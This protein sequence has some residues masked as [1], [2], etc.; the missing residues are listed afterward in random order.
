MD[1]TSL[2]SAYAS[3]ALTPGSVIDTL[4]D[5]IA[6]EGLHPVW[7][8]VAPREHALQRA[9]ALA[10]LTAEER[11]K[12]PLFAVPF[13]VKDN[14]D[15][16]GIPTTAGCAEFAYTPTESATVVT[17]L[18]AAGAILIGKTN[19]DQFATGLVGTRSP[20]GAPSSVFNK[21]YIS[22]GSSAG[23]AVA[24]ASGL[25]SFALGTDTAGSGR[26]PAMFNN[27]VGLK[28]TRGVLSNHG[29]VP[30]CRTLDCVSI[31]AETAF[32]ASLVLA[33]TRGFDDKDSLSRT[34]PVGGGAAPW[35]AAETFRFGVPSAGQL[36]FFGD[37]HNLALFQAAVQKLT[38]LGG[39][40]VEFDL[41]PFLAAAQL[42]Y[43]GPW[44]AERYAAI[45][46]FIESHAA[47]MDPS[48]REIILGARDYSAVDTFEAIYQL[49]DLRAKTKTAWSAFDLIVLPTAP[50]TYTHAEI[51][52]SPIE[53]NSHLGYYTNFVNLLD[54]SAIAVPAGFRPD[55]LA[56]GV[57]LIAQAFQEDALLPLADRLQ[58]SLVTT[59]GG[60]QRKLADAAPLHASTP[61][62]GC[63][64]MAVVGAHLSGQPLN[65]QLT[66][67]N[68]RLV[69][70][71]RT[72]P[73]YKFYALKNTT[74]PK[75]GLVRVPGYEGPG[76]EVEVWALPAD[77][78]G[79]FVDGVPQP[80]SIGTLRLEDGSL[81]KGF[82]VEPSATEDATE[83][84]HLGGWRNY[85]K[86]LK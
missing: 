21:D 25:V 23:S 3:G 51:A 5:R 31:F 69:R 75:P 6:S 48:V 77:T 7:I 41:A 20:F 16:A 70:T 64:L 73:D 72:H 82:L 29:V 54:L 33:A 76:I 60:S 15:V 65:W 79:T 55:G 22:G 50:R 37:T 14:I 4:Y 13:A 63:L 19:L 12:L 85:L 30:A 9:A 81:V 34:L 74:P 84:T 78:V 35:A 45:A 61:P 52:A 2:Q 10:A 59:L 42:L 38:A 18:E 86:T 28:P 46:T 44:V 80:L 8:A 17:R 49:D 47:A 66:Q 67:R 27:L 26:V 57:S 53:R 36:E 71:C 56:F 24:V 1:I 32:D 58:R 83:I 43:K 62:S 40:P 39:Q 11:A 68:G